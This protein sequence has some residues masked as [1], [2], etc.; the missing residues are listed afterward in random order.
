MNLY[1]FTEAGLKESKSKKILQGESPNKGNLNLQFPTENTL[2][3]APWNT[4][5]FYFYY[6][7]IHTTEG[8]GAGKENFQTQ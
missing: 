2:L 3:K 5:A 8:T 7:R 1:L 6:R 4:Y